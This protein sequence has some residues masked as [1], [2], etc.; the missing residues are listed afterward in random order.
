VVTIEWPPLRERLESVRVLLKSH[1]MPPEPVEIRAF[2]D[3]P[4]ADARTRLIGNPGFAGVGAF[5][6]HGHPDPHGKKALHGGSGHGHVDVPRPA[7]Q[8][9][10]Q[11]RFDLEVNITGAL[12]RRKAEG[13][14]FALKLVAVDGAGNDVPVERL[15]VDEVVIEVE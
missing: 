2:V 12:K 4:D 10:V 13:G 1:H 15:L 6:G 7:P 3:Q 8:P 11:E 9:G 14:E 5:F